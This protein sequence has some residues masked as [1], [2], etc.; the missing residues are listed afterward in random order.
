MDHHRLLGRSVFAP[1]IILII[2]AGR[3]LTAPAEIVD[4]IAAMNWFDGDISEAIALA[5]QR[6]DVFVVFVYGNDEASKAT[7]GSINSTEVSQ[8][9]NSKGFVAIKLESGCQSY[10][11]FNGEPIDV[12]PGQASTATL[13][14]HIKKVLDGRGII[15]PQEQPVPSVSTVSSNTNNLTIQ[16]S[17][18]EA[19]VSNAESSNES[20][21]ETP[22]EF[23][24][25]LA[26]RK[27]GQEIAQAK[28]ARE[29]LE[30][31]QALE[32]RRREREMERE[33]RERVLQQ[34]AQDKLE[35][36][37]R[38]ASDKAAPSE[39]VAASPVTV[40]QASTANVARLQFRLPDGS[41]HTHTF[42]A[43]AQLG[44]VRQYVKTTLHPGAFML[45]IAFPRSELATTDDNRSLRDLGLVPSSALLI[46]PASSLP[47]AVASPGTGFVAL[48]WFVLSP[49]TLIWSFVSARIWGRPDN[50]TADPPVERGPSAAAAAAQARAN[51][52]DVR[53]RVKK[54]GNVHRLAGVQDSDDDNNTYNGNSTQQM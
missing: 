24:R 25:E 47:G 40:S 3:P 26:R 1:V 31:Q 44:D 35:R 51:Q 49:I 38:M 28:K 41:S 33:A 9:L 16:P 34:I 14:E 22:R 8:K 12:V 10:H 30:A 53:Q 29:A 50:A 42:E 19:N 20:K 18:R 54:E 6:D 17:S 7:L 23:E 46:L 5:R 11:H 43:D 36:A 39:P 13:L 15:S 32:E 48:L 45:S 37:A 52:N 4:K 27:E 21:S 2:K